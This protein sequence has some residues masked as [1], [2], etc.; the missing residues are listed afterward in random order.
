MS[1]V[2][3]RLPELL[4]EYKYTAYRLARES[5]GRISLSTIYRLKRSDGRLEYYG[6][7]LCEAIVSVLGIKDVNQLFEFD[8]RPV[9][10]PPPKPPPRRRGK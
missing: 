9:V 8:A 10:K 3:L 6:A 7:A 1:R 5:G 4:R 2:R